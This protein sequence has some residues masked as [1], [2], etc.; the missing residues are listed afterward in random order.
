MK[1]TKIIFWASTIFI[2]LFEGIMPLIT[3]LFAPQYI[4]AGTSPLGYPDYFAVAL[5]LFKFIGAL[6]ILLPA[7]PDRLKEWA[8][9]GLTFNLIFAMIS[10]AVV[11]GNIGF[12]LLPAGI[13]AILA[14]SYFS[15]N[16][17]QRA[18]IRRKQGNIPVFNQMA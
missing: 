8:Y 9:A 14:M 5:A 17:I 7:I 13:M 10:H 2:F 12:I 3:L 4:N 16:V 11:D 15:K 18:D 1:K 6:A